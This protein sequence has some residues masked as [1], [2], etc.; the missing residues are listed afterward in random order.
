MVRAAVQLARP[1]RAQRLATAVLSTDIVV[2]QP[3]TAVPGAS[4]RGEHARKRRANTV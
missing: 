2:R 4:L 3:T 1:A